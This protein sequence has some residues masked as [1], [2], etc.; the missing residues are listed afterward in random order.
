MFL[1]YSEFQVR[2]VAVQSAIAEACQAAGRPAGSAT[3]LPVTKNH[4]PE[5]A[6]YVAQA[7]LPAVGENRVQEARDKK[8][9][10]ALPSLRWELIGHL[11]SNKA[12][13]AAATFDRIQSVDSPKLLDLLDRAA[14]EGGRTL[15]V[16]LQVNAGRDPAKS[17]CSLEEAPALLEHALRCR[18]LLVDGLMTIAPLDDQPDTARRT[19]EALRACRDTLAGQFHT[20]LAE[21][22]MG[23]TGD[24]REAI[25]AGSTQVR[26]GTALFGARD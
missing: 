21:L 11:Q 2:L 16:L 5:A 25:L 22:S 26:V 9:A 4:P 1:T 6:I 10:A 17:G 19:F 7:G 8:A 13:L 18:S 14:A 20:P 15:P 23:M 24:L 12:K 3:L